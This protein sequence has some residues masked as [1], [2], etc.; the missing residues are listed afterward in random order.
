ME[1]EPLRVE[2]QQAVVWQEWERQQQL[3]PVLEPQP[4]VEQ[5]VQQE[6]DLRP[7]PF[8]QTPTLEPQP[9]VEQMLQQEGDLRPVP[10]ALTPTL[11]PQ[12]R[13]EQMLQ[14]EGDLRQAP[15]VVLRP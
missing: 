3:G 11:E 13:V 1:R 12:P 8:A 7:V 9:R 4:R 6:G 5:I 10:F 14:Q 15:S 2:E